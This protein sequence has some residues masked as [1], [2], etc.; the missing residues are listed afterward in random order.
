MLA[1]RTSQDNLDGLI[2]NDGRWAHIASGPLTPLA[3]TPIM[4]GTKQEIESKLQN[5]K[6]VPGKPLHFTVS[7]LFDDSRFGGL[8][9][10]PFFNLHDSRYAIYFLSLSRSGYNSMLEKIKTEEAAMLALDRRTI[11]KVTP[12][13]QQPEVDHRMQQ[14]N[15]MGGNQDNKPYRTVRRGG[16]F[17]YELATGS[18]SDLT[19]CVGYWDSEESRMPRSMEILIDGKVF[20]TESEFPTGKDN[21]IVR[22]E[23][24][25]PAE[26][27]A[28]KEFVRIGFRAAEGGM[29]ARV[30]DVRILK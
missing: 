24:R 29:A 18:E 10:E 20:I 19:L 7:G 6:P 12:A 28:G 27:V 26:L 2:S 9:L 11:D 22:K 15:S 5:M 25:I 17:S 30:F 23:Y 16:S 14:E 8:E 3:E 21:R 1:A 13:E 4:I